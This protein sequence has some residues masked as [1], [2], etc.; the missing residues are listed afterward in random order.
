MFTRRSRSSS[1]LREDHQ[2]VDERRDAVDLAHDQLPP[3]RAP[4]RRSRAMREDLGGAADAAERILHLVG[5]ARRDLAER[6]EALALALELASE[7]LGCVRS[8][9]TSTTPLRLRRARRRAARRRRRPSRRRRGGARSGDR[10][11]GR[12]APRRA[13]CARGAPWRAPRPAAARRERPSRTRGA[14]RGSG[15]P[16]RSAA[17]R[18]RAWSSTTI[19]AWIASRTCLRSRDRSGLRGERDAARGVRKAAAL[20]IFWAR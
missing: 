3:R 4:C 19:P 15:S 10:S 16:R 12:R 5:D 8:R 17:R 14:A 1:P 18:T 6:R 2:V 20:P 13:R 7:A 11:P 9:S